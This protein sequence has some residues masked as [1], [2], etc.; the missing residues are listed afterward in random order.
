M[1]TGDPLYPGDDY[2]LASQ[3]SLVYLWLVEDR[4][5]TLPRRRFLP[6]PR[7]RVL[8]ISGWQRT[9]NPIYPGDDY[10]PGLEGECHVPRADGRQT[11]H[12]TQ[13]TSSTLVSQVSLVY[14]RP[15]LPRRR[16]LPGLAGESGVP[17]AGGG[18]TTHSN[19]ATIST[20]ASQE[21]LVYLWLAEDRRP[22]LPRR[23]LL[24]WPRR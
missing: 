6:W 4:R 24:P 16:L 11:N 22:N 17:L 9:G 3:V 19:Q 1:C 10:Y 8:C 12:S 5:P 7:R 21:S 20:L 18:Q 2:Y 23:R 13:A 15:T 14:R